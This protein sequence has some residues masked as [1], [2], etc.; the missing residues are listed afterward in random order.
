MPIMTEPK[1]GHDWVSQRQGRRGVRVRL[2]GRLVS[3]SWWA[4]RFTRLDDIR[5]FGDGESVVVMY[6]FPKALLRSES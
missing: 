2:V 5:I 3:G 4:Q 1:E 6:F